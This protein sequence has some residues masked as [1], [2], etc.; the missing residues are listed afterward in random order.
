MY[1]HML[2]L[3][4]EKAQG[5]TRLVEDDPTALPHTGMN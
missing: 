2:T 3:W 5:K 4:R 1:R